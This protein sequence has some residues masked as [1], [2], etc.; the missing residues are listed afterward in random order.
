[1][2]PCY[3]RRNKVKKKK[4]R[5]AGGVSS[6]ALQEAHDIFGDVDDYLRIRKMGLSTS[7]GDS[8]VWGEKRIEDEFEPQ[9][10]EKNY[11][12]NKDNIIR[13]R[14]EPER[15]QVILLLL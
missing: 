4:A 7:G 3:I 8:Q 5:Q 14:D 11:M 15:I 1:M 2:I 13:D 12:T 6:S 9:I 10:I